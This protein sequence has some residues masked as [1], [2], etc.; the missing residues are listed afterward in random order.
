MYCYYHLVLL[1][2]CCCEGFSPAVAPRLEL[3]LSSL[4]HRL[5]CSL[6]CGMFLDLR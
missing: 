3:G 2:L 6:A 4:V 5:S 1:G